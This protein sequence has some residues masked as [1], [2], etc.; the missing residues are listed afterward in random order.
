MHRTADAL[1]VVRTVRL[2]D[3]HCRAGGKPY[4]QVD[5]EVDERAR[6]AHGGQRLRANELPHDDGVRRVVKLLKNVPNKIGKKKYNSCFQIT[7]SVIWFTAIPPPILLMP[8]PKYTPFFQ[9]KPIIAQRRGKSISVAQVLQE[10]RRPIP[11]P[12]LH[13]CRY[14]R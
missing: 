8:T 9:N 11:R 14:L 4:E 2:R 6:S 7:P 5:E 3:D 10:C 12:T 1:C 13:Q